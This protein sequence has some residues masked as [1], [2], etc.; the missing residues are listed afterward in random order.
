[1]AISQTVLTNR[2]DKKI[3][4]GK[5]RT[6]F[7]AQKGPLNEAIASPLSQSTH[8]LWVQ[9]EQIPALAPT[10]TTSIVQVYQY[11]ASG[12]SGIIEMTKDPTVSSD[13]AYLACGTNSDV[14]TLLGGWIPTTFGA[15][16]DAKF[17][18]GAAGNHGNTDWS[19]LGFTQIFPA[20]SGEEWYF[21]YD[22][23][24][25][26]FAGGNIPSGLSGNALYMTKGFKYAGTIGLS[27]FVNPNS[28]ST[29][30]V[31]EINDPSANV[32]VTGVDEIHFDVDSGFALT[33]L[34]SNKIK[35]AMESTFKHWNVS[36]QDKLTAT[37][38]DEI[39]I[40]E[41]DGITLTTTAPPS[42]TQTYYVKF[43]GGKY[44][45]EDATGIVGA[46]TAITSFNFVASGTY[47]FDLSNTTLA[48]SQFEFSITADGTHNSG[49][50]YTTGVSYGESSGSR[51]ADGTA[52][53]FL[54]IKGKNDTPATLYDFNAD[55][56]GTGD[57]STATFSAQQK[58]LTIKNSL[59][60][61]SGNVTVTGNL[62]VHGATTT[63]NSTTT[64]LDDPVITLGGDDTYIL[65]DDNKDRGVEFKWNDGSADIVAT[66]I[67][68]NTEYI[69][70]TTGTTD[71]T[72]LGAVDSEPGTKFTASVA[73]VPSQGTGTAILST[74]ANVGFFGLDDSSGKFTFI[75]DGTNL[76]EIYSGDVGTFDLSQT[77]LDEIK[78]VNVSSPGSSEDG[79]VLTWDNTSTKFIL[80]TPGQS[81]LTLGAPT[82]TTFQDGAYGQKNAIVSG[83]TYLTGLETTGTVADAL[84]AVNETIKNIKLSKYVQ[85]STFTVS[86]AAG[87]ASPAAPLSVTFTI[88]DE[89]DA[90]HADWEF[91]NTDTGNT[92]NVNDS[93]STISNG[94]ITQQF[95]EIAGGSVDVTMTLKCAAGV[96]S[97]MTEGSYVTYKKVGGLTLW[98]PDPEPSWTTTSGDTVVDLDSSSASDRQIEFDTSTSLYTKWWMIEFGDGTKYPTAADPTE[99]DNDIVSGVSGSAAWVSWITTK[100]HIHDYNATSTHTSDTRFSPK[101]YCRSLTARGLVGHTVALE[102]ANHIKGY[103]TPA[104][105][106]TVQGLTTG[107]N[108]RSGDVN[109]NTDTNSE[110]GHPV[111]FTNTTPNLGTW[112]D[113]QYTWTWGAGQGTTSMS[114]GSGASGD[115]SQQIEKYF[116]LA[117]NGTEETFNV[118]LT[119]ANQRSAN[120]ST[121]TGATVINTKTDPRSNFTAAFNN[122]NTSANGGPS[123]VNPLVGFDFTKYDPSAGGQD[124]NGPS[125]VIDFTNTSTGVTI[126]SNSNLTTVNYTYDFNDSSA[127]S[128]SANPTHTYENATG[129]DIQRSPSLIAA[130]D[131]SYGGG[132]TSTTDSVKTRT[133][134]ITIKPAPSAPVGLTGYTINIPTSYHQGTSPKICANTTDNTVGSSAPTGGTDVVRV[135]T[136]TITTEE[137]SGW[138]NEF[139]SNGTY[140]GTLTA[141]VN[142]SVADNGQV[143]FTGANK[144]ARYDDTGSVD[145]NGLLEVTQE[146]DAN[147]FDSDTYPDNFYK[148]YKSKA[149]VTSALISA[150][151]NTI[152]LKHTDT[153]TSD[154]VG[155]VYDDMQDNPTIAAFGTVAEGTG[156]YRVMSGVKFYKTGATLTITGLQISKLTGRTYRNTTT[157]LTVAPDAGTAIAS[158]TYSYVD[159]G[160]NAVPDQNV[161]VSS[162]LTSA[163]LTV[164]VNGSSKGTAGTIKSSAINVNGGS[165]EVSDTTNLMYWFSSP[166]LDENAIPLNITM[167]G[168][169][170]GAT[171]CKRVKYAWPT[172]NAAAPDYS[173]NASS[174]FYTAYPWNSTTDTLMNTYEAG[175]F[176]D[177]IQHTIT[178]YSTGFLPAGDN[179]STGTDRNSSTTQYFTFAFKRTGLS[180][181]GIKISGEV[182]SLHIAIPGYDTD[183]TSSI[184]GWLDCSI[185]YGGAEFPGANLSAGGNGSDGVRRLGG[186]SDQGS[187]AV[188]TALTD[189]YANLD[190][191][192]ANTGSAPNPTVLVRFGVASGKSVTAVSIED[193][194]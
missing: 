142:E 120:N 96:T 34:G 53:A 163:L 48:S 31:K 13:R 25:F 186:A 130:T 99:T 170:S 38:V 176:L 105:T 57:G 37:A 152:Q 104:P 74:A 76:S 33:D 66:A 36:G 111:K 145:A 83:G 69:I 103:V 44:I 161:G 192:T 175:C 60:D 128:S 193:W 8:Q 72:T 172:T 41:G 87:G 119:A 115:V 169:V 155:F 134:Y 94:S 190:L 140:S 42:S 88:A 97:G 43:S 10:T 23:G 156:T 32:S 95:T 85:G 30:V 73:G 9:S 146:Q 14:S 144:V 139:P 166:S 50:I 2:L 129:S 65:V 55:S 75:P 116:D 77:V 108:D 63:V 45:F 124:S 162:A 122:Q 26:A 136:Q 91:K 153:T 160:L 6:A 179:L 11:A 81:G 158:Q 1:M 27:N 19:G 112:G 147:A 78:D 92:I 101:V 127:T 24:V 183:T 164:N 154:K 149:H 20:T 177:A 29:L 21:D 143:E 28:V 68:Q 187:F 118:T 150:G 79:K 89:H 123:Y 61:S 191:G 64:T 16:Y 138:A 117:T 80:A 184:N 67:V 141:H 174:D 121:T 51:I 135:E 5:A 82:D 3:N 100:T 171:V 7:D 173:G 107:N 49:T 188:N 189:A 39:T 113:T 167:G 168:A 114:G 125:K 126:D 137:Q 182:T 17:Y 148:Q 109:A 47:I 52:G 110:E 12:T 106:F 194:G 185:N 70:K 159:L 180:K 40:A 86:P 165:A 93:Q 157:P 84:D 90:T 58:T 98:T 56:G 102:K 131:N 4:Y 71:W 181:M 22:S 178:D 59:V 35:I 18:I 62:I 151:Y 46:G 54:Q 15:T 133:N 132:A